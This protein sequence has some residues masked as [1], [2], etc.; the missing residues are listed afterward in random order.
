LP[1]VGDIDLSG[2]PEKI[3]STA[4]AATEVLADIESKYPGL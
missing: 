4:E 1:E 3:F 2:T